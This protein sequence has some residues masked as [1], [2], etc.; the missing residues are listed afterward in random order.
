MRRHKRQYEREAHI[1]RERL[2]LSFGRYFRTGTLELPDSV[3][4]PQLERILRQGCDVFEHI[5]ICD[6]ERQ[7]LYV[8]YHEELQRLT[9]TPAHIAQRDDHLARMCVEYIE[10]RCPITQTG[11]TH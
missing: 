4:R 11:E 10:S 5:Q 1:F 3:F 7:K 9:L 2:L 8:L 6:E